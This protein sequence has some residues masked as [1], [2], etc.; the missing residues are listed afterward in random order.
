[1]YEE[2]FRIRKWKSW[3]YLSRRVRSAGEWSKW[4]HVAANPSYN[5][6]KREYPREVKCADN[7]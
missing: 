1:M 4:R 2:Q 3:W 7:R 6:I 5:W